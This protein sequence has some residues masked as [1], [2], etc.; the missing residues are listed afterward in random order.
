MFSQK[1]KSPKLIFI[2]EDNAVYAKSLEVFLKT[3]F[4]N[5]EIKVFPVGELCVD[6]LHQKPDY[7]IMDYFLDGRYDDA[8]DGLSILREIKQKD[9][10]ARIII[11]SSQQQIDVALA[12][13]DSGSMYVMKNAE[14]FENIATLIS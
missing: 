9:P 3:R 6:N 7:I 1:N 5:T 11:L 10:K 14:A 13:K 8:Q 4:E 2:V 12:V